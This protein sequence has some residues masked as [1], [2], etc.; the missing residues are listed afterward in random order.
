MISYL[1]QNKIFNGFIIASQ[2]PCAYHCFATTLRLK[3]YFAG[4]CK[5]FFLGSGWLIL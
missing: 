2:R 3:F 4:L 5:Q 1:M